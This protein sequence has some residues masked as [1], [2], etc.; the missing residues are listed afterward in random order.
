MTSRK[1]KHGAS[2]R[3]G[4]TSPRFYVWDEGGIVKKETINSTE[5]MYVEPTEKNPVYIT[6]TYIRGT[7]TAD[8]WKSISKMSSSETFSYGELFDMTKSWIASSCIASNPDISHFCV[9]YVCYDNLG[10]YIIANSSGIYG[11]AELGV[12]PLVTISSSVLVDT[13]NVEN[14]GTDAEHAWIMK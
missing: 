7:I 13:S 10:G 1:T 8:N 6:P 5:I 3:N 2:L 9:S 14:I 12:R 11:W 4:I